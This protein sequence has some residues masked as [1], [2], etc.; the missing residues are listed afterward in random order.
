[1]P[2]DLTGI[3][4]ENEFYSD[5]YLT[6]VFEGDIKETIERWNELKEGGGKAP[7]QEF[8]ALAT[9][10]IRAATEYRDTRD[11]DER[12][13]IFREFTY[14]L[15][16][17]LG[18]DRTLQ[19]PILADGTW[20]P[21]LHRAARSD[22]TDHLW[23]IEA[24]APA[25]E[26]FVT[27]PLALSF[28]APLGPDETGDLP[29]PFSGT[30]EETLTA[31]IFGL[32]QPP[33]FV[34][35]LSMAQAVLIDRNK[36]GESRL[37]RFNFTEIFSRKES[38][39]MQ[40]VTA[41]LHH[42]CLAPDTGTPLVDTIDEE[43]HRHAHGVS[44]DLK[45]ALREAIELLGNEAA[46]KIVARRKAAGETAYQTR[47][48]MAALDARQ[49]SL[50]SLR[51]MYRLL[52]LFYIEARP[53]LGFAPM[54]S[55]AYRKGY[56][57]ESLRELEMMSLTSDEE[58]DGHYLHES[59]SLL[60]KLIY[61]GTPYSDLRSD[62][63]FGRD[64]DMRPVRTH[65]FDPDSTPMLSKVRF[66]N[67]T[68]QRIIQLMS[69]SREGQGRRG[70]I[71]YAQLGI[72]QLGAVYEALL[73]YSGFFA[74]TDLYEVKKAGDPNPDPL[75]AAYFVPKS[76]I[77]KYEQDE[78]VYDGNDPRIY[79]KG[80]FIYRLAGRDREN[81][82]SYYTPEIL[83]RC[84]V[85]YTLKELLKEKTADDILKLTVCEPAMGSA[86]FLV[87]AV[88]Q[89]SDAYLAKKQEE[90]GER[91]P[92]DRYA[93]E[94]QK[95]RAYIT[96]RNTFGVDLN[97]IAM[98]LGQVSL[99]LNC[100]HE[101]DF[102]PWFGD[103]LFAGNSL[104]G[105]RRE[106]Y[107]ASRIGKKTDADDRWFK[108]APRAV[109][110]DT[111]RKVDEVYHFLLPDP[112]M[113]DY[114][115]SI[116]AP[117]A[118]DEFEKL[119]DWR[120]EFCKPLDSDEIAQVKRLSQVIDELL[121]ENAKALAKERQ[122][123]T[124]PLTVWGQPEEDGKATDFKA[125]NRRLAGMRGEGARNAVPY[126]R[127]KTAMDYWCALW[128]WPLEHADLL[129][130][131][132]EFL[133]D[134]TLILEGNVLSSGADMFQREK[135][136]SGADPNKVDLFDHQKSYGQVDIQT[137][138]A[139]SPR[140]QVVDV[141]SKRSRFFHW[142]VELGDLILTK[143]GFDIIVG[144]PPWIKLTWND[145]DVLSDMHPVVAVRKYSAD[146]IEDEKKKIIQSPNITSLYL[147]QYQPSEAA[148][149]FLGAAQNY[150]ETSGATNLYKCF[151]VRSASVLASHGFMGMLHPIGV[152]TDPKGIELRRAIYK[153]LISH[154]QFVNELSEI[155]FPDVGHQAKFGINIYSEVADD[156]N[157]LSMKNL[158]HPKAIEESFLHDGVGPV[159]GMKNDDGSWNTSGHSQRIVRI[160]RSVLEM[161]HDLFASNDFEAETV[162][163]LALHSSGELSALR[164]ISAQ[165]DRVKDRI[166]NVS[167]DFIWGETTD[168]K[169]T[170]I[171]KRA[172]GFFDSPEEMVITGPNIYVGN[173]LAKTP[174]DNC[175]SKGD[176]DNVDLLNISESYLPRAVYTR[177]ASVADY[178]SAL[179]S[180][181][182]DSSKKHI[183]FYRLAIRKM[184]NS[185]HERTIKS[186]VIQ[187]G[188]AHVH[189]VYSLAFEDDLELLNLAALTFS[190]PYDFFAKISGVADVLF[191]FIGT[192][193]WVRV[194]DLALY[195]VLQL[196]CLTNWYRDLWKRS[197][198]RLDLSPILAGEISSLCDDAGQITCDWSIS[199]PTI[200]D[201]ERR[202]ALLEIDV[203][204][205]IALGLSCQELIE[206]Y[207]A[208]FGVLQ[209]CD[210]N[211]WYD[212][213]GRIVFTSSKNLSGVGLDRKTWEGCKDMSEG[214]VS[215]IFVDDT[216]PGG[217]IE[218]TVNYA[219]PFILP[220]RE[221]DYERIW[222][223]FHSIYA[224][225]A[226]A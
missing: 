21:A 58:K 156:I 97:P 34:L 53:D 3:R 185:A 54:K 224:S 30:Y 127:L 70:R 191:S 192:M 61:E 56:S 194:P 129:P 59:L 49:L 86:A 162:P 118:P 110:S 11:A 27:D 80:T 52:F 222:S 111:P 93:Y 19:Q 28:A 51:Y 135:L 126:Q 128:F 148:K 116:V 197:V 16:K 182:W 41:L 38:A 180:V 173:P 55:D 1:M 217:P 72:N 164:A 104:I 106:V 2:I 29:E 159:V 210:R 220:N 8:A 22:G 131:R 65:L 83:T 153:R 142:P 203:L 74:R 154:F 195:R 205:S 63:E 174:R 165:S 48:G 216:M 36:W 172:P 171:I 9:P 114:K 183:D 223:I 100:I 23:V 160:D 69:L 184:T 60:F 170:K 12:V 20:L 122:E 24:L 84:L 102:V 37:L 124:D 134:M 89:L 179:R 155:M 35:I 198:P 91:I 136:L 71:S 4:N 137:L 202:Q 209:V 75:E 151:I 221:E 95:V 67:E 196:N 66:R 158:L 133:L 105:A 157:F 120:K 146:Q 101:G 130:S 187:P 166:G 68:L 92:H 140:L 5:H 82:A 213:N 96:D 43:S 62:D 6:T 212:Q 138:K 81:S 115:K 150:W 85:K 15:L 178:T 225:K 10:Y 107:P 188:V 215:K 204:V 125:K 18:Y 123:N 193:P 76:D 26:D 176:F 33:R 78:I 132:D 64:F 190:L 25:G 218:R 17:A 73:S 152:L 207:R 143:G 214:S 94:R 161:F 201:I 40:A 7:H 167:M 163:F 87:E 177:R 39:T 44:K 169:K 103:Q 79:S 57:L 121:A 47:D 139:R 186:A 88:N 112:S 206:M 13:Q 42:E 208:E 117:L 46:E 98:E 175:S 99:W 31:G 199:S 219:A 45:Y 181:E 119:K 147:Q 108:H 149:S 141:I 109:K 145:K 144:N 200:S 77:D 211:T 113:A 226:A 189:T 168:T 90:L 14:D 50:E 32:N